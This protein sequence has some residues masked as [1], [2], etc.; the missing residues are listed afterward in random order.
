MQL[1]LHTTERPTERVFGIAK[2]SSAARTVSSKYSTLL[3]YWLRWRWEFT[4]AHKAHPPRSLHSHQQ[5][6][7]QLFCHS[8]LSCAINPSTCFPQLPLPQNE[9]AM[10][11]VRIGQCFLLLLAFISQNLKIA[12]RLVLIMIF[13]NLFYLKRK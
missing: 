8:I 3:Q 7:P 1:V 10:R 2:T 6:H 12:I 11:T 13:V 4:A 5:L 9:D